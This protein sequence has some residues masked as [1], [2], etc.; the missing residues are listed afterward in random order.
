MKKVW[1]SFRPWFSSELWHFLVTNKTTK[2]DQ[3]GMK[4]QFQWLECC[5]HV[6]PSMEDVNL[7]FFCT[8]KRQV[9][10]RRHW[11]FGWSN[12]FREKHKNTVKRGVKSTFSISIQI[13]CSWLPGNPQP[14][15]A[16]I[17]IYVYIHIYIYICTFICIVYRDPRCDSAPW[18]RPAA[19]APHLPGTAGPSRWSQWIAVSWWFS[20]WF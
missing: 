20:W 10:P 11:N 9:Y 15:W 1:C 14:S 6:W 4:P 12:T 3:K 17:Y 5:T 19:V 16:Y 18:R 13:K 2:N 8:D 7:S